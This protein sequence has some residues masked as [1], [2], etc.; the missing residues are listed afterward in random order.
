MVPIHDTDVAEER[1]SKAEWENYEL[2]EK[3]ELRLKRQ[4][5]FWILSTVAVFLALS[6]VPI[7]IER[8]P[9][10]TTRSMIVQLARE[11]NQL[12]R[13]AIVGRSAYRLKFVNEGNLNF[14]VEKIA[15]CSFSGTGEVVRSGSLVKGHLT[16]TYGW[17]PPSKGTE[18][19]IPGLVSEFCYDYLLGSGVALNSQGVVGFGVILVKDLT[20]NRLDRLS[21]L[22]LSGSSA[23]I[24][25]D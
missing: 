7:V 20:E 12:K 24:S 13:D 4:K 8:W 16:E 14:V 3:V 22:L 6:A 23:E 10:W 18:L 9:K 19:G 2:W 11:I 5:R 25:F 1:W 15:N 17:L 21:V